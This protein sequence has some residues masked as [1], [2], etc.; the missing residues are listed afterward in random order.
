LPVFDE[1]EGAER[2]LRYPLNCSFFMNSVPAL[3]STQAP[4]DSYRRHDVE[5]G[6][7][8]VAYRLPILQLCEHE[9]GVDMADAGADLA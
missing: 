2:I 5:Q 3:Y 4:I 8:V 9:T 6:I 1:D 7:E